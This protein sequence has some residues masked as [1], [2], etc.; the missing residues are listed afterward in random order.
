MASEKKGSTSTTKVLAIVLIGGGLTLVLCCGGGAWF[1]YNRVGKMVTTDPEA[2]RTRAAA[3]A[4]ITIPDTYQPQ[5]SMDMSTIGLPMTMCMFGRTSGDGGVMLMEMSGQLAQNPEQMKAQFQQ[6]MQQQG[7]GQE[8]NVESSETRTYQINGEDYEFEFLKGTRKQDNAAMRQ[9]MGVIPGK[10]GT[11]FLMVFETEENWDE[12][13][14]TAMIESM[15][16]T[17]V[18]TK[19]EAPED[20]T[21]PEESTTPEAGADADAPATQ[22]ESTTPSD[23]AAGENQ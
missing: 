22:E 11:A 9:V 1:V 13:A 7:Q 15:G 16:A 12:S 21:A 17:L 8:I 4:D 20:G 23:G 6:G 5:M 14:I 3:I 2:V 19:D 18:E 10:T